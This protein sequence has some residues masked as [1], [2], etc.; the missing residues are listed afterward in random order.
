[1]KSKEEL[2]ALKEEIETLNK[3]LHE[4]T[5]EELAQ[6]SGGNTGTCYYEC[7]H[8]GSYVNWHT[9]SKYGDGEA[10]STSAC[11]E[12]THWIRPEGPCDLD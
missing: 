11:K 6:V 4:L 10:G 5:E 12:C 3:K 9:G 1:M 2:N 7:N 8:P